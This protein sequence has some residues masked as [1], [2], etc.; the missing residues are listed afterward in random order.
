MP[1]PDHDHFA[2]LVSLAC[3]DLRTPLAT[4]FGFAR[5]LH[6]VAELP[7][8]APQY[9]EMIEA[10]AKQLGELLDELSL[11]ARIETGRYEPT[12]A[13]VDT[14]DLAKHAAEEL[15]ADRVQVTGPGGTVNVD[16][17][18]TERSVA[19]LTQCA[20]RHGGLEQVSVTAN[21]PELTIEPV[22]T[23]SAPVLMGEQLRDL[24]AAVATILIDRLGG[25]VTVEG[26]RL[27]VTLPD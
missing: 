27:R 17:A 8:P 26:E 2:R 15:G 25:S 12:L 14:L 10:S 21:G 24:G 4:V 7:D 18:A 19:A 1:T 3:H 13:P 16:V 20:L 9:V 5:T 23:Y 11:A 22:T 6:R